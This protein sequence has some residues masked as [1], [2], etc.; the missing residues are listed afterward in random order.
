MKRWPRGS[1]QNAKPHTRA[2]IV[3]WN[4]QLRGRRICEMAEPLQLF[5]EDYIP[6]VISEEPS[7]VCLVGP[8]THSVE[9]NVEGE[10]GTN[11]QATP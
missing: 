3:L 5:L 8:K 6:K 10:I 7:R 9:N 4:N 2:E 11:P 1:P